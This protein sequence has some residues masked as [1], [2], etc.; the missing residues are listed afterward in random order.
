MDET[1]IFVQIYVEGKDFSDE[2]TLLGV[3]LNLNHIEVTVFTGLTLKNVIVEVVKLFMELVEDDDDDSAE[4]YRFMFDKKAINNWPEF[5]E[6]DQTPKHIL[7]LSDGW[8]F[9]EIK[10][11]YPILQ[12]T[13]HRHGEKKTNP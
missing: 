7:L 5:S 12:R 10:G 9:R 6:V 2:G 13:N 4:F 11:L 1:E 3:H 8:L